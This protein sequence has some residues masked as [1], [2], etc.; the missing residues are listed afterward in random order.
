[1]SGYGNFNKK[2]GNKAQAMV[3]F[4]LVFPI[5]IMT[6]MA[7]FEFGFLL[8]NYI[9]MNYALGKAS[10][11]SS[12]CRGQINSELKV[13]GA[14]LKASFLIDNRNLQIVAPSGH[15]LGP[16]KLGSGDVVCNMNDE[17]VLAFGEPL[18]F[19]SDSGTSNDLTDD[20]TVDVTNPALPS[21]AKIVV[22]YTHTMLCS[23]IIGLDGNRGF[24]GMS[25]TFILKLSSQARLA[26]R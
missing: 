1:M 17:P 12:L 23:S 8:K 15:L 14:L 25:G 19:F 2:T 4:A 6:I 7:I 26:P 13:V 21:Y 10:A 5:L 3:E 9:G 24:A 18:F 20:I 22:I 16:Y 11:E